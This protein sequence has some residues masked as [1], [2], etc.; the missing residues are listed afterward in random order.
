[1]FLKARDYFFSEFLTLLYPTFLILF[2]NLA[3]V[4]GWY[5]FSASVPL[6]NKAILTVMVDHLFNWLVFLYFM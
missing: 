2:L 1:M 6:K 5:F 3:T 4:L